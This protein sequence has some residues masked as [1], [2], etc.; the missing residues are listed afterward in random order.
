MASYFLFRFIQPTR[1]RVVCFMLP[2]VLG[3]TTFFAVL[4]THDVGTWNPHHSSTDQTKDFGIQSVI[5]KR[6]VLC[7]S[8]FLSNI[9][10]FWLQRCLTA[11][12]AEE[13]MIGM[14]QLYIQFDKVYC[15]RCSGVTIRHAEEHNNEDDM[16]WHF[17]LGDHPIWNH[18]RHYSWDKRNQVSRKR[19]GGLEKE[20]RRVIC[21][22]NGR[23]DWSIS[24]A[25]YALHN[26]A[27]EIPGCIVEA[28]WAHSRPPSLLRLGSNTNGLKS[29]LTFLWLKYKGYCLEN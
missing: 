2:F 14:L 24:C 18:S 10:C 4:C 17:R 16:I 28:Q 20:G 13:G 12:L 9:A 15:I 11:D 21:W 8:S 29:L 1:R 7:R 25:S 27:N 26:W 3:L 6:K 19:A 23:H 5:L 22:H